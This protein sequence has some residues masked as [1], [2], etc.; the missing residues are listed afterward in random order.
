MAVK[1]HLFGR[2]EG[3]MNKWMVLVLILLIFLA[4]AIP[5]A[6]TMR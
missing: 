4:I 1:V 6:M 5:L 2:S 3:Q